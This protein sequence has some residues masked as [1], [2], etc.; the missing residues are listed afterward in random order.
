MD[1]QQL[2]VYG[3]LLLV[4]IYVLKDIC[5]FNIPMVSNNNE[6]F[7]LL[8]TLEIILS[9]PVELLKLKV[10]IPSLGEVFSLMKLL[11][12]PTNIKLLS[13]IVINIFLLKIL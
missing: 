7:S 12:V 3:I 13:L 10:Y 2:I 5:G 8:I 11:Y 1:C 9:S 6:G 4:G